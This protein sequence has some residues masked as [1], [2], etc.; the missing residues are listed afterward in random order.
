MVQCIDQTQGSLTYQMLMSFSKEHACDLLYNP[1]HI[2][3]DEAHLTHKK[4]DPSDTDSPDHPTHFQPCCTRVLKFTT[5]L[6]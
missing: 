4:S 1:G 5:Y 6:L 3:P 2:F